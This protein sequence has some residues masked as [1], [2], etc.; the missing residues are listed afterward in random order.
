MLL[1]VSDLRKLIDT[2]EDD[3]KLTMRLNAVEQSIRSYTNNNFLN[4]K[5]VQKMTISDGVLTTEDDIF[6][7]DDTVEFFHTEYSDGLYVI[8]AKI[9]PCVYE[10]TPECLDGEGTVGLVK[11]PSDVVMGAVSMIQYDIDVE[12][13]E[14]V[15]NETI[16][17]HSVSYVNRGQSDTII[18]YPV[19]IT[20]FLKPYRKMKR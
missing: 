19:K 6:N 4:L 9:N 3:F 1:T 17:R 16:S 18:G 10:I 14:D 20:A 8:T 2:D 12:G 15:A 11:Y 13:R 5:T 7:V